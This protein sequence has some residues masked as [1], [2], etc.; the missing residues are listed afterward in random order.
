[1]SVNSIDNLESAAS[2]RAKLNELITIV[3]YYSSSQWPEGPGGGG[4]DPYTP[5]PGG[6]G[7]GYSSVTIYDS[8]GAIPYP[9]GHD[10]IMG[11]CGAYPGAPKTIY[12]SKGGAN[13]GASIEVGDSVWVDD[14]GNA[15]LPSLKW[16][17]YQDYGMNK[18]F[19]VSA[20]TVSEIQM[21]A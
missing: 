18:A 7:G 11:A 2:I 17:G 21:C 19:Y 15:A 12:Y 3:N 5:P 20:G 13:V 9:V 14:A 4:G 6:G 8:D 16:Y 10:T 1:M